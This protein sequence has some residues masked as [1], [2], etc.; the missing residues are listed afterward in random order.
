LDLARKGAGSVQKRSQAMLPVHAAGRWIL[1]ICLCFLNC[2]MSAIGFIMQRRAHLVENEQQASALDGVMMDGRISPKPLLCVG[3][4]MY[5]LAAVPDVVAYMLV[6]QVVCSTVAC[7]RLV[8]LTV[9]AHLFLQERIHSREILGMAL[10]T[11]GTAACVVFGPRPDDF[12]AAMAGEFHHSQVAVYLVMG[13][14][15]LAILLVVEHLE[16]LPWCRSCVSE[17]VY[18]FALPMATGLAYAL[19]KVFNTEIGFLK[20]PE[21][22]PLGLFDHPHWAGMVVAIGALGLLDFYLNLRGAKRM[23]VQA[24]APLAF[25]LGTSLQYF[26]SIAVFGELQH[27]SP[28]NAKLSVLGA[29]MSLLGALT[30]KPPRFW[31]LGRELVHDDEIDK[32]EKKGRARQGDDCGIGGGVLDI[33][34]SSDYT[35]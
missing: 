4:F 6:P 9:F 32:P 33:E 5:I 29:S 2:L 10:C 16:A 21:R 24:F 20:P 7:F 8:V 31:L 14:S 12:S 18:A 13:L 1:G 25:A 19:E 27:L 3:I 28:V 23:P 35:E 34:L 22:M 11:L 17:N 15:I 26:Q 30:I